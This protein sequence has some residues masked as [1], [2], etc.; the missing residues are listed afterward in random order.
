MPRIHVE[1]Y[2]CS[3]NQADSEIVQGLLARAGHTVVGSE[4]GADASIILSCI[5]K[6]PTEQKIIK[7]L[8]SLSDK[9]QPLIVAGCMPKALRS[10]VEEAFPGASMMGPDD[11]QRVVEIVEETLDGRRVVYVEGDP[12]DRTRLPRIRGRRVIHIAPIASGC[13]GN[14]SYCIVRRARGRLHSFHAGGI[15]E[16]A[17]RAIE[18]G[19]R[20]VWLTA[21]DT[22][23]YYDEGVR[24]P[25]LINT[26][27][28]V[29]GD[30]R[31]RVGMMTPNQAKPI[32]DDLIEAYSSEKVFKFL[33]VPVQSGSDEVLME[34]RRRYTV[35]EFMGL[36]ARFRESY[37]DIGISTDI[38]CGFPGE[39]EAQFNQSLSL[40][41]QLDPD[42]LNI[43]R[44]WPRPGTEAAQMTGQLHG[45]ETKERSRALTGLW[46]RLSVENGERWLGWRGEILIDEQGKGCTMMGR[47]PS[48]KAVAVE[49]E[50]GP[51]EFVEV[52]VTGVRV[53]YLLGR[54]V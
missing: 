53:G 26:L 24:L 36:V 32:L 15:V 19:C 34:M 10:R 37:P 39:T 4:A 29:K 1:A 2:G 6:T 7:R 16:D 5:V 40:V 41:K 38:I 27:T 11:I 31:I 54:T 8:R 51:G 50:A 22:A 35:D 46:K 3:A 21:E 43:S 14:C 25:Q 28:G 48:Y 47:T 23:A 42:V 17:R 49:T 18:D 33:H 45:R 20:E 30:F 44:F 12:P 13:L 9:G 52:E